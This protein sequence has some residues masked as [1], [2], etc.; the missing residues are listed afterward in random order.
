MDEHM[1]APEI[2]HGPQQVLAV[3]MVKEHR[4]DVEW[5]ERGR[6]WVVW[7]GP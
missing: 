5:A 4:S 7:L 3:T 1:K 6:W 2:T